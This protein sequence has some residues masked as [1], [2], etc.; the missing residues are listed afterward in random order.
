L[1]YAGIGAFADTCK[2]G[3]G[4]GRKSVRKLPK[5]HLPRAPPVTQGISGNRQKDQILLMPENQQ[6][7]DT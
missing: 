5:T 3:L 6:F 7:I 4:I 1:I 2:F